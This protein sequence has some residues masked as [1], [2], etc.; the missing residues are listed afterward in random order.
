M[1]GRL[2]RQ[3]AYLTQCESGECPDRK[4]HGWTSTHPQGMIEAKRDLPEVH[5]NIQRLSI[6]VGKVIVTYSKK[7][8]SH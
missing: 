4:V 8:K 7:S 2:V 5:H 6:K 1:L 3:I